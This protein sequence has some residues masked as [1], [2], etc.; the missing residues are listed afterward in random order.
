[1]AALVDKV[2]RVE[3]GRVVDEEEEYW[4]GDDS[5]FG[6]SYTV[7]PK[8]TGEFVDCDDGYYW[9]WRRIRSVGEIM[10]MAIGPLQWPV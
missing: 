3:E 9:Q 5:G 8:E 10:G 1:M 4:D 2:F 7:Y 6:E